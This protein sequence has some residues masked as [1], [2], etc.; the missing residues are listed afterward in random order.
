MAD[1]DTIK[2]AYELRSMGLT[3]E[4]VGRELEVSRKT[5]RR[6]YDKHIV[7]V[8][9]PPQV[10]ANYIEI[11]KRFEPIHVYGD[12]VISC[13]WHVP[14]HSTRMVNSLLDKAY[15]MDIKQLVIAGDLFNMDNFSH[16]KPYQPEAS[17]EFEREQAIHLLNTA[18]E[19]FETITICWGN[20][21]FRIVK[22]LD[23]KVSFE[24]CLRWCLEALGPEKHA[25]INISDL[26]HLV[27]HPGFYDI[28][29]CHQENFSKVPLTVPRQLVPKYEMSVLSAHSHHFAQGVALDGH[30][31]IF[32]GGGLFSPEITQYIKRTNTHHKWVQGYYVWKDGICHPF[33]PIYHN[34]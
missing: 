11:P 4:E 30:N 27:Y 1:T 26:D 34:V 22:F 6:L 2:V 32:E 31:L 16:Y 10:V 15:E 21:D 23:F 33:S 19:V 5:A 20:H 7:N 24:Y 8:I 13:D 3:W 17:F 18:L 14:L 28:R 12:A 29:L 9:G 25:R